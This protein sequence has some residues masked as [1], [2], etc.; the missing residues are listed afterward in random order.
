EHR[1]RLQSAITKSFELTKRF[2]ANDSELR[3]ALK[4]SGE[5]LDSLRD[6][7]G[8]AYYTTFKMQDVYADQTRMENRGTYEQS[9]TRRVE[10]IPVTRT[11]ASVALRSAGQDG[12]EGTVDD[13][14]VGTFTGIVKEQPRGDVPAQ[15]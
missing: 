12:R 7:W 10:V 5:Q 2:P 6:P 4:D 9:V 3:E 11:V 15:S 8:H 1:A 13:F 14:S